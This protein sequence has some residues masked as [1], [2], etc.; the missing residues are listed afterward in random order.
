LFR[1]PTGAFQ[2]AINTTGS[3]STLS[4]LALSRGAAS[5]G[6]LPIVLDGKLVGAIGASGGT[7][8]QDAV[9]SKLGLAALGIQ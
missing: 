1:R 6:G 3:P 2:A 4:L 9:V 8:S 5:E 7:F